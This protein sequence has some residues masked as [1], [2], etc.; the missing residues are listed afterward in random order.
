MIILQSDVR[1]ADPHSCSDARNRLNIFTAIFD[2]LVRR[3]QQGNF[4]PALAARWQVQ[5]DARHWHFQLRQ[6]VRFHNGA[7]LTSADVVASLRR[8]CDPAVGGE[9]GTE[10]VWASYLGDA[11]ISSHGPAEVTIVTGR[12][13]ADLLDLLVAIPIMPESTL[14]NLSD[15]LCGSGPYR[16]VRATASEVELAPFPEAAVRQPQ[17]TEPL[18]WRAV[19]SEADRLAALLAGEADLVTDLSAASAAQVEAA[20]LATLAHQSNLCVA[21]LFNLLDGAAA[22]VRLRQAINYAVDVEGMIAQARDGSA[23]PLNGPLTPWHFGCDP[24]IPPYSHDPERARAL[25]AEVGFSGRLRIDIPMSLPDEAP[26][27][28][29]LLVDDLAAVGLEAE[30]R[31]YDDRPAYAQ[32]VKA[33]QIGDLCCFD[34]SPLST[35]RVLR[36][37]INSDV[38]GPWWQGYSNAKVN[39]L[40]DLAAATI[41]DGERQALY[42]AA[43]RIMHDEAPWIFLYRPTYFWGLGRPELPVSVGANGFLRLD[44]HRE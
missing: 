37:K 44:Q 10:G 4:N 15:E 16:F 42:R 20:G 43:Y 25:I 35:Y 9:L 5:P 21:F 11:E 31:H 28:G 1:L 8:A 22:D 41:D 36:E 27:L 14:M 40:L 23:T 13:M 6:G 24:A 19:P 32:M 33:K 18:I 3:D 30:L 38:A 2:A 39:Q 26:L 34:S 29:Q 7:S 17:A 12:P